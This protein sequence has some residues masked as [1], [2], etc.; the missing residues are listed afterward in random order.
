MGLFDGKVAFITGAGRGQGRSHALR[1]ADEGADIIALDICAD[2]VSTVGY[3]LATAEDL[4][5]TAAQVEARGRRVVTGIADVRDLGQVQKVVDAGLAEL[6]KIDIVCANAGVGSWSV[7]WEMSEQVWKDMI[8]VNLTG[9]FN[10]TRAALPSMVER[11]QGGSVVLT[12]STAG[13]LGHPNTAHYTAA[14]HGIIGFMKVLAQELGPH[15]IRVNSVCPTAVSTPLI[16]NAETFKLFAP[17]VANP[18]EADVRAPFTRL[19]VLPDV[20][21]IEPADVSEAVLWLCS[22]AARYVTGI[23]LPVDLGMS[24]KYSGA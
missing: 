24:M 20:P 12:S 13:L 15:G 5:D 18:T 23:A 10:T 16:F 11:G 8:D 6:G 9:V 7:S 19:N 4:E 17:D 1:L 14:K 3:G 22:D 21:W 2:A